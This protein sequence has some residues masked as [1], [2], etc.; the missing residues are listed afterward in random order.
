MVF[1]G[2]LNILQQLIGIESI[3]RKRRT[4]QTL[5]RDESAERATESTKADNETSMKPV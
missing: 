3:G 5:F 2:N 4:G 1:I